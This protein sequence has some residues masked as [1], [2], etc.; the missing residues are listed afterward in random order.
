VRFEE[1]GDAVAELI[2]RLAFL[3]HRRDVADARKARP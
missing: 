2:Q 1:L 3:R